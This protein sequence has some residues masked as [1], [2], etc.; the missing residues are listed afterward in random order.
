M[1]TWGAQGG[2]WR[3]A[4]APP[5]HHPLL[6]SM[7]QLTLTSLLLC[8]RPREIVHK[9]SL[10]SCCLVCL[11]NPLNALARWLSCP[12]TALPCPVLLCPALVPLPCPCP[13]ALPCP[14]LPCPALPCPCPPALPFPAL[15]LSSFALLCPAAACPVAALPCPYLVYLQIQDQCLCDG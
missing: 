13:P 7:L 4:T 6:P 8:S 3:P 14:A 5:L 15:P 2:V 9:V 11:P 10:P 12:V 1:L